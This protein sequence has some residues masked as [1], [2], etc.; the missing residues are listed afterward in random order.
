M[1]EGVVGEGEGVGEARR[2][3]VR[4]PIRQCAVVVVKEGFCDVCVFSRRGAETQS[5]QTKR[6]K[7]K[8]YRVR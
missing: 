4:Y 8:P 3:A 7:T 1:P 2:D 6:R 5:V